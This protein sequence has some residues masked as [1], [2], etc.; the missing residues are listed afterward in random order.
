MSRDKH[1]EATLASITLI[2]RNDGDVILDHSTRP[3]DHFADV[4]HPD[5]E[6]YKAAIRLVESTYVRLNEELEQL[7]GASS[8]EVHDK[9]A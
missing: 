2:L 8:R 9:V 4:K 7:F 3:V 5:L 1:I 6:A